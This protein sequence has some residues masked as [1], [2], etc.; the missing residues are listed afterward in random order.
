MRTKSA[1]SLV[2]AL[3]FHGAVA[4]AQRVTAWEVGVASLDEGVR[5]LQ[6][7]YRASWTAPGTLGVDVG[8]AT[9]PVG[10]LAFL[11]HGAVDLDFAYEVNLDPNVTL[12]GRAGGTALV[13]FGQE[14]AGVAP[15]YNVGVGLVGR[16]GEKGAI[17]VDIVR[18]WFP[19]EYSELSVTSLTV[20]VG[21]FR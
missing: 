14:T 7:G 12:A 9:A 19:G 15:A 13:W 11:V 4:A 20:G 18:R 10:L 21:V 2:L 5:V 6:L 3:A 8:V 1:V 17:R 16:S